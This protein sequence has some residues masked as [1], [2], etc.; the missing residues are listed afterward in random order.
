MSWSARVLGAL[1]S[2]VLIIDQPWI[3]D[4]LYSE[5]VQTQVME[6]VCPRLYSWQVAE[7]EI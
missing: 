3:S 4:S 7:L 5:G 2:V 1:K 6:T